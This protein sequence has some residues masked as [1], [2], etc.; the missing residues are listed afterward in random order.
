ME[1]TVMFLAAMVCQQEL[2]F[3]ILSKANCRRQESLLTLDLDYIRRCGCDAM[4]AVRHERFYLSF[5]ERQG[6]GWLTRL[7][8]DFENT[9][10]IHHFKS[11]D[12]RSLYSSSLFA[13]SISHHSSDVTNLRYTRNTSDICDSVFEKHSD[14]HKSHGFYLFLNSFIY[15]ISNCR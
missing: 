10:C 6:K 1:K 4:N 14:P 15:F 5:S 11:V 2:V 9:T 8:V 12:G 7:H 13:Q 3:N